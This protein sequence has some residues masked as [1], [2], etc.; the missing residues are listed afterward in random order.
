MQYQINYQI[1]IKIASLGKIP[2]HQKN[3]FLLNYME[4]DGTVHHMDFLRTNF[5]LDIEP[6]ETSH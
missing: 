1:P 4:Y 2:L 5:F 6:N 3:I